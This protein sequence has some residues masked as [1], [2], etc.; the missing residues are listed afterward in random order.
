MAGQARPRNRKGETFSGNWRV[1][2]RT[3]VTEQDVRNSIVLTIT[4]YHRQ[5]GS[6]PDYLLDL[7]RHLLAGEKT[8]YQREYLTTI[9]SL[10]ADDLRVAAA[11]FLGPLAHFSTPVD[12]PGQQ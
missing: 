3:R 10:Q 1:W 5:R 11:R 7:A 8:D 4:D 9:R 6:G 2:V 12:N